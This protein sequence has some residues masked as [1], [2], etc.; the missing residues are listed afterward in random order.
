M[1]RPEQSA[2]AKGVGLPALR[3]LGLVA[4]CA[5]GLAMG[6]GGGL[7]LANENPPCNNMGIVPGPNSGQT[8]MSPQPAPSCH[9]VTGCYTEKVVYQ[10][11]D[12][13]GAANSAPGNSCTDSRKS[14]YVYSYTAPGCTPDGCNESWTQFGPPANL[15]NKNDP[16]CTP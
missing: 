11:Y 5:A 8:I 12:V 15:G 9:G 10:S 13:C 4:A 2:M 7:L 6:A 16:S 14:H 1:R 3:A